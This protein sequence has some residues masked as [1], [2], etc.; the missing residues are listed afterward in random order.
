[1]TY[2]VIKLKEYLDVNVTQN[3]I[4]LRKVEDFYLEC[5]NEISIMNS[6][7]NKGLVNY[8]MRNYQPVQVQFVSFQV[9][10]M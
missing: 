9:F 5:R 10:V 2:V 3:N 8:K 7:C 6:I 4:E 1:M